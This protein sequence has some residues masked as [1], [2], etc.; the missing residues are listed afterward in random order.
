MTHKQRMLAAI[1]G[2]ICPKPMTKLTYGDVRRSFDGRIT[3]MGGIPSV[4][5]IKDSMSDRDFDLFVKQFFRELG[6]GDHAILGI[7]DT[8]PPGADFERLRQ[9]ARVA[10]EFG[11]ITL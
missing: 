11:A 4:A 1:R 3:I 5:L 6:K 10:E 9:L 2:V 8:T 7:S